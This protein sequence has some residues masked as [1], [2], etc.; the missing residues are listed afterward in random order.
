M[1]NEVTLVVGL[2]SLGISDR[3]RLSSVTALRCQA[4]VERKLPRG[5]VVILELLEVDNEVVLDRKDGV[6]GE[7]RV[8]I[9]VYLCCAWLVTFAGDLEQNC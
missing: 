9:G 4:E 6:R 2:V 5:L 7:V 8:V 3:I 1:S